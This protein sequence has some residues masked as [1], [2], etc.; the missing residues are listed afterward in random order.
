[1]PRALALIALLL[2]PIANAQTTVAFWH[3]MEA[4]VEVLDELIAAYHARQDQ[5]RIEPRYVG[6]YVEGQTRLLAAYGTRS[7]P[8]LYQAEIGFFPRLV[9]DGAVLDLADLTATL[10]QATIDDFRPGAWAYGVWGE[11]RYGLPWNAST[12]VLYYNADVLR[13][14]GIAPP[15]N[16]QE[17]EAAART[18]TRRNVQGAM[19]VGDAWLFEAMVLSR[20]GQLATPDG[21]P[22]LDSPEA[23]AALE[24]LQRLGRDR[25]LAY[26]GAAEGTPAMLSF[27]RA[28][29]L[30]TFASIANWPDV[31]RFSLLFDLAAAPIPLE[32]GGQVPLGG[33]QLV[34]L[35]TAT[36]EERSAAFDFWAFL[37]EPEHEARW[38]E[39]TY[40]VPLR[41]STEALLVDFYAADPN[42]AAAL[43]SLEI[44]IPRPRTS[45]FVAWQGYLQEALD[46]ALRGSRPAAAALAEA[47]RRALVNR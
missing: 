8:V 19:L 40:Y 24:M 31:R 13:A 11:A 14:A 46:A 32:P 34:V 33:A 26:Y 47:Q 5:V 20:G 37:M 27:V 45:A 21:A 7:A 10:P 43:A 36:A 25:A 42:R 16:W 17:F 44:A 22:T 6:S 29:N 4:G 35:A 39:A 1:M 3:S 23:I 41:R 18:L 15:S 12:P 38:I 2:W 30:L 28:R 9:E